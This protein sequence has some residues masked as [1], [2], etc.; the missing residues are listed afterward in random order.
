VTISFNGI[1]GTGLSPTNK[2]DRGP[3]DHGRR[4]AG[5]RSLSAQ[6]TGPRPQ[7]GGEH[8]LVSLWPLS[9]PATAAGE[10]YAKAKRSSG[11]RGGSHGGDGEAQ[12]LCR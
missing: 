1:I 12:D 11:S 5:R 9:S 3:L 4:R 2:M 10:G 8:W 7:I 6:D